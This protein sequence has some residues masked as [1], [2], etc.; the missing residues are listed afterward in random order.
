MMN[1]WQCIRFLGCIFRSSFSIVFG[2]VYAHAPATR[3]AYA[4]T[5][6]DLTQQNTFSTATPLT[7]YAL[8]PTLPVGR[9]NPPARNYVYSDCRQCQSCIPVGCT[10]FRAVTYQDVPVTESEMGM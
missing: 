10:K 8:V 3:L 6:G 1:Y 2:P 9:S 5:A 4:A 7:L